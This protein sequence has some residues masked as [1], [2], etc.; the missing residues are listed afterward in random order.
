[1]VNRE[2]ATDLA[3]RY[4]SSV[5]ID[6]I[7]KSKTNIAIAWIGTMVDMLAISSLCINCNTVISA[8]IDSDWTQVHQTP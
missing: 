5:G 3:S 1:M 4:K 2:H 8:I 7:H 6:D